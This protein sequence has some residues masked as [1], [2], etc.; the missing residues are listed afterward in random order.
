MELIAVN[1][2]CS[3]NKTAEQKKTSIEFSWIKANISLSIE[4]DQLKEDFLPFETYQKLNQLNLTMQY[5]RVLLCL[6]QDKTTYF[7]YR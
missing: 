5:S 1:T 7:D 4:W 3:D 2:L 6:I